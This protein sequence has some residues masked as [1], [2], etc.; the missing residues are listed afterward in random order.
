VHRKPALAAACA[1]ATA[2]VGVGLAVSPAQAAAPALPG[3]ITAVSATPGPAAGEVTFHWKAEGTHTTAFVIETGLSSFK[4]G[5]PRLP[6]HGRGSKTFTVSGKSRSVTLSAAQVASAGASVATAHHLYYRFKAVDRTSSGTSTRS[7]PYQQ[8]VAVA[9][10]AVSG[11]GDALRVAS[12]NVRTAKD[13]TG[14]HAWLTRVPLVA[15]E[16]VRHAP[17]LVALQE[18]NPGRADGLDL[19]TTGAVRQ[20]ESLLNA[21]HAE[22]A[23][24]YALVRTTPYVPSTVTEGTQGARIMYDTSR[25]RLLS[26]CH[27]TTGGSPY[28]SDCSISTPVLST[29]S[30]SAKRRSAYALF[31]DRSSG[32]Q[33]WFVSVHLDPRHSSTMHTEHV[34]EG[35]RAAQMSAVLSKI[36]SLNTRHLPVVLGGD[37]NSWQ[38]NQ[39]GERAHDA[40]IAA[41]YY[42]S[43]AA[44]TQVDVRYTT[45]S[46]FATTLTLPSSGWG[47]RLD[48]IATHGIKGATR[49]ENV[50]LHTDSNRASDHNMVLADLRLP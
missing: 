48:V 47:A 23:T 30:A 29:D 21:V 31:E 36:S 20:T 35:L 4:V 38:N 24:Q 6:D 49:F 1:V 26:T 11:H 39:G 18:L 27:E 7:W 43:A 41:G 42:D 50:M 12:F 9:P 33:F 37:T 13:N 32:A 22:G 17:D 8:W 2:V 19:P 40:L 44:Q 28:S 16:I 15:H 25:Y 10:A 5:D 14:P 34:Y 3:H 45:M 46:D